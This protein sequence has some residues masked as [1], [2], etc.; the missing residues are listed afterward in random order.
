M[1]GNL[2]PLR[3]AGID[4][5][6]NT[7]LLLVAEVDPAGRLT[8]L[9]DEQEIP[10]LGRDLDASGSIRPA[11]FD[12]LGGILTRYRAIAASHGAARVVTCATSA[13]RNASNREA[14]LEYIRAAT[15][16]E[17]E[18]IDGTTE[19]DLTFRGVV[20]GAA[21]AWT[22]PAVLDIG[23]GST[24]ISYARRGATN[25]ERTLTRVS[26]EI[27]SV[28]LAERHLRH[29]PP[30]A[31]EIAA[32]R[33]RIVEELAQVVNPGFGYYTLI[34][35]AGT[36]TTLAG[37]HLGL[38]GFEREKIDGCAIPAG[39]V[40]AIA[41]RLLTMT[42]AGIGSLSAMTAG[43]ED[44]LGAGALILSTIVDHFG[45]NQICVS[46]RGLRHGIIVREWGR[47][48]GGTEGA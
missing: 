44:I 41:S 39:A 46:T 21:T 43:R 17:I 38:A 47:I 27:G 36:A 6:T 45:F 14:L 26:I 33:A 19:A 24:E 40:H 15:G 18:I 16:T 25:G 35:V 8:V 37:I 48:A 28:R 42:P 20:G 32:A 3:L 4:I 7:V 11:A 34:A 5:G 13:V 29:A 30:L 22:D 12:T 31:G 10:R 23:G 9:A 2:R 1:A